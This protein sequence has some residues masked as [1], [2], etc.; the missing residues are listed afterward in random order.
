MAAI[1]K[2]RFLPQSALRPANELFASCFL[3]PSG[4]PIA[5]KIA[6]G[7]AILS[8]FRALLSTGI[9]VVCG[10]AL[11]I[12]TLREVRGM[13][14]RETG[15]HW[16]SLGSELGATPSPESA[17]QAAP[18]KVDAEAS[19]PNVAPPRASSTPATTPEDQPALVSSQSSIDSGSPSDW[20]ALASELGVVQ[21]KP[22]VA[23][24]APAPAPI[25]AEAT[26]SRS[27]VES[28]PAAPA[29]ASSADSDWSALASDLGIEVETP[30]VEVAS[31]SS[32]PAVP[33]S[34][35]SPVSTPVD[36]ADAENTKTIKDAPDGATQVAK[37]EG[38]G[39]DRPA[40]RRRRGGRGGSRR[41]APNQDGEQQQDGAAA[42][43]TTRD[44]APAKDGESSG[45][46]RRR[47]RRRRRTRGADQ[48]R[49]ADAGA[50]E[51]SSRDASADDL[52]TDGEESGDGRETSETPQQKHRKIPSWEDAVGLVVNA[53]L[54]A[55]TKS[56]GGEKK[57]GRGR[58][59]GRSRKSGS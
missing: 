11:A 40:R 54:E 34:D 9:V 20:S 30:P 4:G 35:A 1:V 10:K 23:Q 50:R 28:A 56:P 47:R 31:Q 45:E 13:S 36:D 39:G 19:A 32:A 57:G 5:C 51:S 15:S 16:S 6:S 55:R 8:S 52:D 12:G 24:P 27:P 44:V 42:T 7:S 18:A 58:G 17:Q 25:A 22:P 59:R 43:D 3:I 37:S 2:L 38:A 46:P 26:T 48:D 53:N 14:D 33:V 41:R 29:A 21:T 49:N